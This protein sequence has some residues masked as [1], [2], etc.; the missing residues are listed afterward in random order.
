MMSYF[1]YLGMTNASCDDYSTEGLNSWF[2]N[3]EL[4]VA[5]DICC[6][7]KRAL[8]PPLPLLEKGRRG[9][10]PLRPLSGVPENKERSA[11]VKVGR[12]GVKSV[13]LIARKP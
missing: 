11:G 13:V 7:I 10:C 1:A 4:K 6:S 5:E 9:A 8:L 12:L 3:I 2:H